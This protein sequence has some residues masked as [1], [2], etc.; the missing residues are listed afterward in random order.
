MYG[1]SAYG[2]IEYGGYLKPGWFTEY[3]RFKSHL[4]KLVDFISQ[5][6]REL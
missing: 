5:M 2:A 4:T 1:T 6:T 3:L